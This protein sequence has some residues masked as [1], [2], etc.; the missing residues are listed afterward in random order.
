M[1]SALSGQTASTLARRCASSTRRSVSNG[2][3]ERSNQLSFETQDEPVKMIERGMGHLH[4]PAFAGVF[5][6]GHTKQ[7]ATMRA[8]KQ[9]GRDDVPIVG[10]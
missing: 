6:A 3:A 8:F 9:I 1:P 5:G 10:V 7:L 2:G 4:P